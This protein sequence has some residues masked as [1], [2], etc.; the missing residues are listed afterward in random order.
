[1][2][3]LGKIPLD[4]ENKTEESRGYLPFCMA[5]HLAGRLQVKEAIPFLRVI[6]AD[7]YVSCSTDAKALNPRRSIGSI[8]WHKCESRRA[9][10]VALRRLGERPRPLPTLLLKDIRSKEWLRF[11][12]NDTLPERNE[13]VVESLKKGTTL[14]EV[15]DALG[16]PTYAA[17]TREEAWWRYDIDT[18]PPYS[19]IITLHN[20]DIRAIE[21]R[22]PALWQSER[23]VEGDSLSTYE[24][25]Q[26]F[27]SNAYKL[28]Q[29][30]RNREL[31]RL[32]KQRVELLRHVA[33]PA[34]VAAS[35]AVGAPPQIDV[36]DRREKKTPA[37]AFR[38][39]VLQAITATYPA[40][41]DVV[42]PMIDALENGNQ[43]A[44][45]E[46]TQAC[47]AADAKDAAILVLC[48]ALNHVDELFRSFALTRLIKLGVAEKK[49]VPVPLADVRTLLDSAKVTVDA[50]D[51]VRRSSIPELIRAMNPGNE[52]T[53]L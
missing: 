20:G 18:E 49:A 46:A 11:G 41:E 51:T 5:I 48:E 15:L 27:I 34:A 37:K 23:R 40:L 26:A 1:M 39:Q 28:E 38:R 24:W 17:G 53:I 12:P 16:T 42:R 13:E 32:T 52:N 36:A 3:T 4:V 9:A 8:W 45:E 50:I 44:L 31:A 35:R 30:R 29:K 25:S 21:K 6:E 47:V 33:L 22:K 19:L 10:Q 14:K 7:G 43:E 2:S